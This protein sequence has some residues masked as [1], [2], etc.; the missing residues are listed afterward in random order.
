[1]T[2]LMTDRLLLR[3]LRMSD[4]DAITDQICNYNV[5]KN[6]ARVPHPYHLSDALEFLDWVKTFDHKSL[7][8]AITE[9]TGAG[10]LIGVM[11]FEYSTAN[12]NAELGYWL[13]EPHWNRGY[14]REAARA[15]VDHAFAVSDHSMLVSCYFNDNPHSGKVL[16]GAGFKEAGQCMSF[17]K[18]Q[19]IDVPVTTMQLTRTQWDQNTRRT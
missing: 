12:D 14:M 4:A 5:S 10:T 19:G 15:V 17:S 13:A 2:T 16:R 18:S 1:M 9:K 6:L 7:F 3:P 11:S 8:V